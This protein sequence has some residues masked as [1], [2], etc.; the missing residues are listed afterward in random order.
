MLHEP[1]HTPDLGAPDFLLLAPGGAPVGCVECK[2]PGAELQQLIGGAQLEKYRALTPNIIL[3]DYWRFHLL[4]EGAL[5][6]QA[7][8]TPAAAGQTAAVVKLL[9]NFMQAEANTLGTAEQLAHALAG[10]C[11][12]LREALKQELEKQSPLEQSALRGLFESFQNTI[13]QNIDHAA[14]ADALA[15]TLVYSL[16]LAKLQA[17]PGD[18]LDLY[19][20]ERHIPKNFA[21]VREIT[22][23]LSE[24]PEN[25][26]YLVDNIMAVIN[27]MDAAAIA[28]SMQ[29][30]GA[31]SDED[32]PYLIFYE[33]FLAA[34][35]AAL[36]EK[37]GVYYT[38]P[39]VVKFIVRAADAVLKR[40]F[41]LPDGLGDRQ[42]T[43]LDFAAG[44]GTFMLEMFRLA[45]HGKERSKRDVLIRS[46]L[47]QNFFG[48]ELLIAPYVI[49]H[50]KLSRFL[51]DMGAPLGRNERIQVYLTNTLEH[52]SKQVDIPFMPA[53]TQEANQA[54]QLK[55]KQKILVV[56]GNPP[57][58]G[59]SQN[60]GAWISE[61]IDAYKQVDG[62]NLNERNPKSLQDDYVKFIRFAQWKMEQVE[63]GVVAVITNHALS[64]IHI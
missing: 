64:L 6:E 59:E 9:R 35:D 38:P 33:T 60:K 3:T 50:L 43:A 46:H 48:F 28:E 54:Q 41:G 30:R 29:Y 55:A 11:A 21:L 15:Q 63:E 13:Y 26:G 12:P 24:L 51:S 47:L 20:V 10:R 45:L 39:P 31:Y 37:R 49:A 32:D 42:V 40:D 25:V 62:E 58:S 34:Y 57:Y 16:L 7:E 22:K 14:F 8:L 23:Y 56:T 53:L 18:K 17:R 61:L 44:T 19:S 36:R 5:V 1:A 52:A 4:R 27:A 2:K